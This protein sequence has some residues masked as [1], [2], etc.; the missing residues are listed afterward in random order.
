MQLSHGTFIGRLTGDVEEKQG[1]KQSL[2]KFS[3]AINKGK[4]KEGKDNPALFVS[5]TAYG[6]TGKLIADYHK[7]GDPIYLHG[8]I[9]MYEAESGKSY[10]TCFVE[11]FD[12]VKPKESNP[13]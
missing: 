6:T 1:S 12:F 7:K 2:Y 11:K 8:D 9:S 3:I 4:N 10:L 5:C 13:F